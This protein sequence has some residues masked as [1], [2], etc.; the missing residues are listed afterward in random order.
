MSH[1][2]VSL[3]VQREKSRDSVHKSQF[4]NRKVSRLQP[5][6]FH[7]PA[8]RL[9]ARPIR[10]T[11]DGGDDDDLWGEEK[12]SMLQQHAHGA[13]RGLKKQTPPLDF[14]LFMNSRVDKIAQ[15]EYFWFA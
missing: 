12:C 3:I 14:R 11:L 10:L 9:T 2:T 4:M 8:E 15:N 5:V 13:Q 7:L 1:F 6:S